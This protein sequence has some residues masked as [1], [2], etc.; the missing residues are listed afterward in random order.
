MGLF[1][2]ASFARAEETLAERHF[3]STQILE[4]IR[5]NLTASSKQELSLADEISTLNTDRAALNEKLI[6]ATTRSRKLEQKIQR[7]SNRILEQ[8][9]NRDE[10]RHSLKTRKSLLSEVLAALQRM[11]KNP[12]PALLVTPNDALVSVRSAIML[13]SVV[14]E[15]RAETEILAAQ[16]SQLR[17]LSSEIFSQRIQLTEDLKTEAA[18]EQ[19]IS[20]LIQ[21]KKNRSRLAREKLDVQGIK[22]AELAAR[23]TNLTNLISK[24]ESEI[25]AVKLAT[26]AAKKADADREKRHKKQIADARQE[27]L[28]PDFSDS[29]RISPAVKFSDAKGH[30]IKPVNGVEIRKFGDRD[31]LGDP[32]PSMAIA[33]RINARVLSPAD[34]W[35]V[36]SGPFRSY[37]QLLILNV[38]SDYH[39]VL[40]GMEKIEVGLSQFVLAGEPIGLMGSHRIASTGTIDIEL[41]RPVLAIEFR[42][43]GEPINPAQWW[44]VNTEKRTNNDS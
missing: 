19:R 38:G 35:I 20:T 34:G 22:A 43:N 12:P 37:G 44:Q 36:Y 25:K 32:S 5:K 15:I 21:E 27:V 6:S 18:E 26:D 9:E 4:E 3:K 14:P 39:I 13:G 23:A 30:L 29:S 40:S 10:L 31:E 11:G 33:T 8:E 42:R 41:P 1:L 7:A 28:K 2:F 16:L 24:L 17:Q